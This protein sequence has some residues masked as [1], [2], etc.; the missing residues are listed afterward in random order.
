MHAHIHTQIHIYTHRVIDSNRYNCQRDWQIQTD[1]NRSGREIRSRNQGYTHIGK[2]IIDWFVVFCTDGSSILRTRGLLNMSFRNILR[3]CMD[4][5]RQII[6]HALKRWTRS[7]TWRHDDEA[8]QVIVG[9]QW[10]EHW[11]KCARQRS[12]K[13]LEDDEVRIG[14]AGTLEA[15][16]FG[17]LAAGQPAGEQPSD[18]CREQIVVC[19]LRE[20][21]LLSRVQSAAVASVLERRFA[22]LVSRPDQMSTCIQFR[23]FLIKLIRDLFFPLSLDS[24][25]TCRGQSWTKSEKLK[26]QRF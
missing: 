10:E 2:S 23:N 6:G 8:R 14:K 22:L 17:Y 15:E 4:K 12:A 11:R 18:V 13:G 9:K 24:A 20:K 25:C 26:G 16:T 19:C 3:K 7:N 1:S 21:T 5:T